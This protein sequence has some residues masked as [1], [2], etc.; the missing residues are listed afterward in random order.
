MFSKQAIA[1]SE[2]PNVDKKNTMIGGLV[3]F[4]EKNTRRV[5]VFM[6]NKKVFRWNFLRVLFLQPLTFAA[7]FG[8]QH[9]EERS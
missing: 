3:N 7:D 5:A 2:K 9:P 6:L 1:I 4:F 8:Q